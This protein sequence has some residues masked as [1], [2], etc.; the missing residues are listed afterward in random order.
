MSSKAFIRDET[1]KQDP[2][3]CHDF[4][5]GVLGFRRWELEEYVAAYDPTG[6]IQDINLVRP[7]DIYLINR[8]SDP[9]TSHLLKHEHSG[10][11]IGQSPDSCV[12]VS[13]TGRL[14][15]VAIEPHANTFE[16]YKHIL[17]D[18]L[19]RGQVF[20]E[21]FLPGLERMRFQVS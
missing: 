9:S 6:A 13:K 20:K 8:Y 11:V 7:G 14:P 19:F 5:A 2:I 4:V 21:V 3:D 12:V 18:T 15:E 1:T 10:I 17:K 16:E